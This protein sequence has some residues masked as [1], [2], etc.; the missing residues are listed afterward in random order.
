MVVKIDLKSVVKDTS[1]NWVKK[2]PSLFKGLLAYETDTNKVKLFDG[3][4]KFNDLPY[5]CGNSGSEIDLSNYLTKIEALDIYVSKEEL[6]NKGYLTEHQDISGKADIVYVD[7]KIG[8]IESKV[9]SVYKYVGSVTNKELLPT[10]ANIGD[11]YNIEDT[12]MN[13]AWDG[14]K[15]DELGGLTDLTNY[16]TKEELT[17]DLEQ[18]STKSENNS[19]YATKEELSSKA[20]KE[21]VNNQLSQKQDKGD[22]AL[23]TAIPTKVSQL[24]NDKGYLTEQQD[25]SNKADIEYVDEKTAYIE[26][27]L[28][29]KADIEYVDKQLASKANIELLDNYVTNTELNNKVNSAVNAKFAEGDY[30]TKSECDEHFV[31]EEKL[32]DYYTKSQIDETLLK[33]YVNVTTHNYDLGLKAD[34]S[35]TYTKDEVDNLIGQS[36][37][38]S[39]VNSYTKEE[40]DKK[41]A[42]KESLD[43]YA[44]STDVSSMLSR[45][46]VLEEKMS[47]LSKTALEPV[48]ELT[49]ESSTKTDLTKDIVL[50][51]DTIDTTVTFTGKSVTVDGGTLSNDARIIVSALDDIEIKDT[52]IS[53]TFDKKTSNAIVV[54]KDSE[55]VSVKNVVFDS[56]KGYNGF[57]IGVS[58]DNLPKNVLIDS[59]EFNG[60]FDN[61]A[62]S[63][64]G[65]T[66]NA[67]ININNC[68][69]ETVS[70]VLRLS[71]KSNA[72]NVVVNITNCSCDKWTDG[73]YEGMILLQDYTSQSLEESV[74]NNLFAPEKIKINISN[75]IYNGEK[76]TQDKIENIIYLYR[77]KEKKVIRYS[78][79]NKSVLPTINVM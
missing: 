59:C 51:V 21:S 55:Y 42:T 20:D 33:N 15:W 52:T 54:V 41:Y 78:D 56:F 75:F 53:G 16:V 1:I 17:K 44:T 39:V 63:I 9:S 79:E 31:E 68:S 67:V 77:D 76:L 35:S 25:V 6:N 72:K 69:F 26:E 48:T 45:M 14:Y 7:A 3:I 37:G 64:F 12:G 5:M 46:I 23:V 47:S 13:Y 24:E 2:N 73:D 60:T 8:E 27:L 74:S 61:N 18:Y 29:L 49:S 70:N 28:G 65:T 34:K 62:I 4:H 50:D 10:S 40:S 36:G 58:N 19:T 38:G 22:Y 32:Q 43:N 30:Y 71:N 57:E 66:D 11:V